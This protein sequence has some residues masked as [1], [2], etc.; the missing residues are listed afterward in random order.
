MSLRDQIID[1]IVASLRES[2]AAAVDEALTGKAEAPAKATTRATKTASTASKSMKRGGAK[3]EATSYDPDDKNARRL[4]TFMREVLGEETPKSV[5]LKTYGPGPFKKGVT[6][7]D[8]EA[9]A[10]AWA[11]KTEPYTAK[12]ATAPTI[13]KARK[14]IAAA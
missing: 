1:R 9:R 8:L 4:P 13:R 5:L 10:K 2:V 6:A 7:A 12:P 3:G 14:T 11:K